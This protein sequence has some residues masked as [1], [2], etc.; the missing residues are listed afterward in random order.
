[1]RIDIAFTPGEV[2]SEHKAV[3]II[4]DAIRASSTIV[5]LFEKQFSKVILVEDE[6]KAV[7]DNPEFSS[8]SYCICSEKVEGTRAAIA[9]ISP[10]LYELAPI[11]NGKGR[12]VIMKTT[13]GTRAVLA[14]SRKGIDEILIGS[15]L[16]S[17][18]VAKASVQLAQARD[19]DICIVCAGREMGAIPCIDDSFCAGILAEKIVE[20]GT[21]LG[22]VFHQQDSV[23]IAQRIVKTFNHDS[24]LAFSQSASGA[25]M[26]LAGAEEDI[27]LCSLDRGLQLVPKVR[28]VD[29]QGQVHIECSVE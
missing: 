21:S 28:Q 4:V 9:E 10:S 18:A 23:K 22:I 12:T 1:M 24:F 16:N 26:R 5:S 19:S 20:H 13:N 15:M 25:I 6:T 14:L 29:G 2:K 27:R 7:A 11:E 3:C 17:D 8:P